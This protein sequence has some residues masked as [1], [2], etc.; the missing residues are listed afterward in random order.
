M[1]K[2]DAI[3]KLEHVQWAFENHVKA[4]MPSDL[5]LTPEYMALLERRITEL[6]EEL[7]KL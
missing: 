4:Q 6:V 1:Q 7:N 5:K 2:R 3:I